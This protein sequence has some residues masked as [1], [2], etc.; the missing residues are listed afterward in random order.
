MITMVLTVSSLSRGIIH[1]LGVLPKECP[2]IV[3]N[4][5]VTVEVHHGI[6]HARLD[7]FSSMTEEIHYC[8]P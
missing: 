6:E 8:T 3:P 7:G 1:N 2:Q 4:I 5:R